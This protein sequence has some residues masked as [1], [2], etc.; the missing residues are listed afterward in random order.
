MY[1]AEEKAQ[2]L[3]SGILFP[4]IPVNLIN[5]HVLN[6]HLNQT[7]WTRESIWVSKQANFN[8][9]VIHQLQLSWN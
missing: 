5:V 9:M 3:L 8:I 7:K 1:E 4:T 6:P 2:E